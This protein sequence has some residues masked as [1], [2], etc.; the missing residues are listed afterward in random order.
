MR[1]YVTGGA[2][3]TSRLTAELDPRPDLAV[4][5]LPAPGGVDFAAADDESEGEA[6]GATAVWAVGLAVSPGPLAAAM[7][8]C[9]A[10]NGG[11]GES[12]TDSIRGDLST[13]V[14][15]GGDVPWAA[16]ARVGWPVA[17][18]LLLTVGLWGVAWYAASRNAPAEAAL[19]VARDDA[20]FA[21][22]L[23]GRLAAAD[24]LDRRATTLARVRGTGPTWLSSLLGA[25]AA[26]ADPT[27]SGS[28]APGS[29]ASGSTAP[30]ST[31]PGATLPGGTTN[32]SAP[33]GP[34]PRRAWL[35]AFAVHP[36]AATAPTGS[37]PAKAGG[38]L[39]TAVEVVGGGHTDRDV[40]LFAQRLRESG[41][42]VHVQLAA[43]RDA[44]YRTGPGVRFELTAEPTRSA[45]VGAAA[46]TPPRR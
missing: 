15:P 3:V 19:Q 20:L 16:L 26:L 46:S 30:G 4:G 22:R 21:N 18:A 35:E 23:R 6:S 45:L 1:A 28:T 5:P 42:F 13:A 14:R 40:F 17:A 9:G 27:T 10:A 37:G 2:A 7:L 41:R 25:G 8:A 11:G 39:P 12:P 34:R 44:R 24:E 36:A 31:A 38:A 43:T 33:H 29:A 32:E